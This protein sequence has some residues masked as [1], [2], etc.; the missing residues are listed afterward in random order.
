MAHSLAVPVSV[1]AAMV[2][3]IAGCDQVAEFYSCTN[4]DKGHV[5]AQGEPDPCYV[6]S[7]RP[8]AGADDCPGQCV[9]SGPFGW[10]RDPF[11][12]YIGSELEAP[13]CPDRALNMAYEGHADLIAPDECG[14]CS[15]GAP[16]CELPAGL[17]ANS[18]TCQNEGPATVHLSFP[19]PPDWNGT[20][21]APPG[22]PANLL[23]SVT[24]APL[25]VGPCAPET[26][27]IPSKAQAYWKTY[28]RVCQGE[29]FGECASSGEVCAPTA[30]P[31]PPGFFQCIG[32]LREGDPICPETYPVKHVFYSGLTDTRDCTDCTCGAPVGSDCSATLSTYTDADCSTL[33]TAAWIGLVT[34]CHDAMTGSAL[35]SMSAMLVD[36]QPGSC[37]PSGGVPYGEATPTAPSTFCC[38]E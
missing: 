5:D 31:P 24:F 2:T 37:E 10:T 15:C 19:A 14:P 38:Q 23:D 29:E 8:E 32:Y 7:E 18:T 21:V 27:P 4:P 13:A 26:G 17:T 3:A 20:C 30:E 25:T 6:T 1:L 36:N 33:M 12:L 16:S 28:A 34:Q 9:A 22:I 11:L 35:Q